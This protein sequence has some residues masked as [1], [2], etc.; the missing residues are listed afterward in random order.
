M[1]NLGCIIM[2]AGNS[3]RFEHNSKLLE[4]FNG[5]SLIEITLKNLNFDMFTKTV[6]VTANDEI[7]KL[8]D[9][10]NVTKVINDNPDAGL[11]LT[12]KMGLKEIGKDMDGYM[13]L[14]CDQPLLKKQTISDLISLW[15]YNQ[16]YI[17]ALG[18]KE[19]LGNPVIFPGF[20]Y[21]E[22][23][24][25]SDNELGRKVYHNHKEI[26]LKHQVE[27]EEELF[28]VDT[29]KDLHKIKNSDY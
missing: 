16:N 15:K 26:L 28:D 5:E 13:F 11:G 10:Y 17:C 14:V 20:L 7:L 23:S 4:K 19:R 24:A 25:L 8:A 12:I 18:F 2:A 22:L 29:M 21:D 9:S 27:N 6:I 1:I 3:K